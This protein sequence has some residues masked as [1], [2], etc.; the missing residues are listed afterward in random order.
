MGTAS[1]PI[2][3]SLT[4]QLPAEASRLPTAGQFLFLLAAYFG[5]QVIA[6]SFI[7]EAVGIDEADQLVRG[8]SWSWGYG[9]QAPLYTWLMTLFLKTFGSSIFS[10]TLL[11]ELMLF[12]IYVLTYLNGRTLTRS[13]LCG[14]VAAA[15]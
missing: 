13:H 11:R 10:L 8:Q 9:P 6:R 4:R 5:L 3:A 1:A 7:S 14:V 12:G 2:E 15:S